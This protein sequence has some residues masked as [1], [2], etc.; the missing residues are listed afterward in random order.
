MAED[1]LSRTE[2]ASARRLQDARAAGDVPRSS[3][4]AAWIVLL[5]A[6]GMLTWQA[7]RLLDAL[8][9]LFATALRHAAQPFSPPVTDAVHAALSA[10]L[11]VLG[12]VFVAAVIAPLLLSGWVYAPGSTAR[13]RYP[14]HPL[15]R[16]FSLDSA[17]DA[18]FALLKLALAAAAVWW[19]LVAA[20]GLGDLDAGGTAGALDTTGSWIGR[21]V[22]ALATAL[23]LVAALDAGWRWLRYLRRHAMTWQEVVAEARE[24]EVHPEIRAQL[25][26]RQQQAGQAGARAQGRS[27][28]VDSRRLPQPV[29]DE[30]IG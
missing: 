6:L 8:H 11:P 20:P 26:G 3:E 14:F 5:S 7:P 1:D 24:A 2:P 9:A 23:A 4:F 22:L 27:E 29:V 12:A 18:A 28:D 10:A 17:V 30:V 16:L 13:R 19:T 25:R 21:G 15:A